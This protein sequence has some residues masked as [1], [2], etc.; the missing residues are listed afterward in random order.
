ML[1]ST[2]MFNAR[3]LAANSTV[4]TFSSEGGSPN[5][6]LLVWPLPASR[7]R[8]DVEG[9]WGLTYFAPTLFAVFGSGKPSSSRTKESKEIERKRESCLLGGGWLSSQGFGGRHSLASFCIKLLY[10]ASQEAS[11]PSQA[12]Q[13]LRQHL[14][15][16]Q[17]GDVLSELLP[18]QVDLTPS[19]APESRPQTLG[20]CQLSANLLTGGE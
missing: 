13:K 1:H 6:G 8:V 11:L 14:G 7:V 15:S 16:Q 5:H 3:S 12:F 2:A 18:Q 10:A 4:Q 17:L 9:I 20:A 19:S